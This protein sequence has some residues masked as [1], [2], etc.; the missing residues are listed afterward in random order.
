MKS[1]RERKFVGRE[2]RSHTQWARNDVIG[3]KRL[4]A[5]SSFIGMHELSIRVCANNVSRVLLL[6]RQN[7]LRFV[8]C[9]SARSPACRKVQPQQEGS[10]WGGRDSTASCIC[11][12]LPGQ[13]PSFHSA[14]SN[15]LSFAGHFPQKT[16][17]APSFKAC[18][19]ELGAN[20]CGIL[21]HSFCGARGRGFS[22]R[23]L[24]AT[25]VRS[26]RGRTGMRRA[27]EVGTGN[28][29]ARR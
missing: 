25:G 10:R 23:C 26:P 27:S 28:S 20:A 29:V 15:Q 6:C 22:L 4:V 14:N 18:L 21:S 24:A 9:A 19:K 3:N 5:S 17:R 13:K 8:V 11:M 1:S 2:G 16:L 7:S 12:P